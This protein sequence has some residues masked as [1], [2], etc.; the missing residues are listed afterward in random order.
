MPPDLFHAT[1]DVITD[2]L[3]TLRFSDAIYF[4][5]RHMPSRR[6]LSHITTS[7]PSPF[8]AEIL[9]MLICSITPRHAAAAAL[10]LAA[11]V[12][13]LRCCRYAARR[14]SRR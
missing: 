11:V 13:I 4:R 5:R 10:P 14:A 6:R 8:A 2:T 1:Y 9:I 7:L 3:I 12:I